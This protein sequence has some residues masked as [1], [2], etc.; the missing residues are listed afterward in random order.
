MN[1]YRLKND[2]PTA[3]V[4]VNGSE[5]KIYDNNQIFLNSNDNFEIR[6]FNPLKEKI[7]VEII[8]NG[9]KKSNKLL[10][11]NPGED[12]TI[13]RFLDENKK[14]KFSTYFIDKNNKKANNA[15]EKNGIITINFYKEKQYDY[16]TPYYT[17]PYYT[18]PYYTIPYYTIYH[19]QYDSSSYPSYNNLNITID[20]KYYTTYDNNNLHNKSKNNVETGRIEKGNISNQKFE[21]QNIA[22]E[23]IPFHSI[24]YHLKPISTKSISNNN[25]RY[26]C[27][28]CGY[29]IRKK[30]W[31]YCPKCGD[32]L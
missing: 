28:T 8:F 27:S 23:M 19:T 16:T 26:Y 2:E 18:T 17:T 24:T 10:I 1:Y 15:I 5:K 9:Q 11:L 3:I 25:I 6:F 21:I 7:G 13:D 4:T 22:F 30:S 20:S 31:K 32:E 12:I 29:R 14:M